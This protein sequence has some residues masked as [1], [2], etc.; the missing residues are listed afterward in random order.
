MAIV[1]A[2]GRAVRAL[3]P[4]VTYLTATELTVATKLTG[5]SR[6]GAIVAGRFDARRVAA[7]RVDQ[8]TVVTLFG[9]FQERV[10]ALFT[11]GTWYRTIETRL[12]RLAVVATAIVRIGIGIVA[13]LAGLQL[14]IAA[15]ET[16]LTRRVA[17]LPA[18]LDCQTI[19]T[20]T[21]GADPI[22]V[23]TQLG[24]IDS[25]VT[26]HA[27]G[28]TRGCTY[29]A[30]LQ[31]CTV[32]AAAVTRLRH[33]C[34]IARARRVTDAHRTNVRSTFATPTVIAQLVVV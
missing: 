33:A 15:E 3:A 34:A 27:A 8:I 24:R 32:R 6:K 18:N 26:A 9:A 10:A 28:L 22:A 23:I 16:F 5:L 21:I 25:A 1:G 4:V 29:C 30:G 17:A 31:Y 20:A 7:V 13:Y 19:E 2:M 11:R 12:D 14:A